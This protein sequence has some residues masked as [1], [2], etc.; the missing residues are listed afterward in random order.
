MDLVAVDAN[1][2][3][4]VLLVDS[5]SVEERLADSKFVV[6]HQP[7]D[8]NFVESQVDLV[9]P[10]AADKTGKRRLGLAEEPLFEVHSTT[11]YSTQPLVVVTDYQKVVE[12][13]V[14]GWK[15]EDSDSM[16]T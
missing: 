10:T 11:R 16:T 3:S 8:T 12:S 2:G 6:D 13:A 7:A 5:K 4:E 9:E 14:R 15:K 1:C